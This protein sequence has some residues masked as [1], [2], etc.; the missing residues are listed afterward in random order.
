MSQN[1]G[2]VIGVGDIRNQTQ[3]MTDGRV[4]H[5]AGFRPMARPV[6]IR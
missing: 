6:Q 2:F 5:W 4:S 3:L 1:S